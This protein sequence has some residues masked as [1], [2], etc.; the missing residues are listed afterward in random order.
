MNIAEVSDRLSA[1]ICKTPGCWLWTGGVNAAG[2]G[3][4]K[5]NGADHYVH[6]L[7]F[8]IAGGSIGEGQEI[9]HICRVKHCVRPDHLRAV[10]HKANMENQPGPERANNT[11]G[12][13][14][15]TWAQDKGKWRA[16]VMHD[17]RLLH[18]GYFDSPAE[19]GAVAQA[20]RAEL[21][22]ATKGSN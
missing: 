9:D 15:V 5:V 21:F 7:A 13:R 6:R 3:R 14:G 1:R 19:A 16:A 11:S 8:L 17:Y 2:Y 10:S 18:L 12:Y 20:K 22:T 4:M